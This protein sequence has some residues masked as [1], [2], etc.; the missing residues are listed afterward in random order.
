MAT[1]LGRG[2]PYARYG[3]SLED[4]VAA[5][6]ALPEGITRAALQEALPPAPRAMRSIARCGTWRPR[7]RHAGLAAGGAA[8]PQP[9]EIAF[10]LSLDTPKA[11]RPQAP[12]TGVTGRC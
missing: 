1:R 8:P 6:S 2:V 10:T 12:R 5:R 4:A 7:P 11:M 3:E 9:V